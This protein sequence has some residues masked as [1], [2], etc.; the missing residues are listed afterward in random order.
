[1]CAATQTTSILTYIFRVWKRSEASGNQG[2]QNREIHF[3]RDIFER[4]PAL[5]ALKSRWIV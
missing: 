1:M 3:D 4:Q 5:K 2:V